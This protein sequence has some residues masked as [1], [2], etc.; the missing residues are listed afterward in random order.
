MVI[1]ESV[2]PS[3]S[4]FE[5]EKQQH[6]HFDR[7]V[8]EMVS[9]ITHRLTDLQKSGSTHQEIEDEHGVRLI[10]LAGTNS[11]ASLRTELDEKT[12]IH[13]S[14]ADPLAESDALSTFVNSN[15][16]AVNNSILMG[17]SYSTNDP[18]VHVDISDFAEHQGHKPEK[19]GKKGKKKDKKEGHK[20]DRKEGHKGDRSEH[21][22]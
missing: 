15:F 2:K 10:T 8:R 13:I 14:E 19:K 22:D 21:S 9:A 3:H 4:S 5:G 16:Q 18:G 11:G 1:A 20:G 12:G 7:E 6:K 17:G